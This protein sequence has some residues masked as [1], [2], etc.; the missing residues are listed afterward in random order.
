[1]AGRDTLSTGIKLSL[2]QAYVVLFSVP[3]RSQ[4]LLIVNKCFKV[5]FWPPRLPASEKVKK[6]KKPGN[7]TYVC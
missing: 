1:M 7:A 3:G 5:Y 2:N 6:V 4:D